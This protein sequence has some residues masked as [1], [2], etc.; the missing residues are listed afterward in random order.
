M[1]ADFEV[2]QLFCPAARQLDH[3]LRFCRPSRPLPPPDLFGRRGGQSRSCGCH[4][5][6]PGIFGL[7]THFE[8]AFTGRRRGRRCL[9]LRWSTI[10]NRRISTWCAAPIPT[11]FAARLARRHV[12]AVPTGRR[13]RTSFLRRLTLPPTPMSTA[14][15]ELAR[16]ADPLAQRHAQHQSAARRPHQPWAR[17]LGRAHAPSSTAD[18]HRFSAPI[19]SRHL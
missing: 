12:K 14:R 9:P 3:R 5:P 17:A 4:V 11:H 16:R 7:G 2:G 10:W 19:H 13:P 18:P 8:P 15:A 6:G 1:V